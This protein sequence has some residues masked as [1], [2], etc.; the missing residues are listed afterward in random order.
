MS[1]P[2]MD[3]RSHP[4]KTTR[5]SGHAPSS[6]HNGQGQTHVVSHDGQGRRSLATL[7]ERTGKAGVTALAATALLLASGT[8]A[9]AA[10]DSATSTNT[11][12]NSSVHTA[13]ANSS[14]GS[15]SDTTKTT[16]AKN[17]A[18][19]EKDQNIYGILKAN[20]STKNVYVVNQFNVTKAGTLSDYGK[21][22]SVTNLSNTKAIA[23]DADRHSIDVSKGTFYYQG[24]P[25]TDSTELP[26]NIDISYSLN[27]KGVKAAD[28]VGKSGTVRVEI[29]TTK[30][31]DAAEAMYYKKYMLQISFT[32]P[33]ASTTNISA[34]DSGV[35]AD[36]GGNKQI[37]FMVMPGSDGK[38]VFTANSS[39]F[40]MSAIS[41]AAA[42]FSM[43]LGNA[44]D[45]SSLTN[46]MQKLANGMDQ[47]ADGSTT[48]TSGSTTFAN[49]VST[50]NSGVAKAAN[51]ASQLVDG[52]SSLSAGISQYT[53]AISKLAQGSSSLNSGIQKLSQGVQKSSEGTSKLVSGLK[54]QANSLSKDANDTTIAAARE[55]YE[56]A[57]TDYSSAVSTYVMNHV[58]DKIGELLTADDA[59]K[60][61]I[62]SELSAEADKDSKVAALK[63]N[64]ATTMTKLMK[65]VGEKGSVETLNSV[66]TQTEEL[67]SGMQQLA[68]GASQTAD[69]SKSFDSGL[70]KAAQG[71]TSLTSGAQQ[72]NSG[73]STFTSG[74]GSLSSGTSQV[75]GGASSLADGITQLNSGIGRMAESTDA[76]PSTMKKEI[77]KAMEN[78]TGTV[79]PIDFISTKNTDIQHV[80]F[81]LTTRALTKAT[82]T[83]KAVDA[84]TP[85]FLQRVKNL[86]TGS[87]SGE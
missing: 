47:L 43:D 15:S 3:S 26:W 86:F 65:L 34:G 38:L 71:G 48:L 36:A 9:Y 19:Y 13:S 66:A 46:G 21:Y 24:T 11:N 6:S 16:T 75:S 55:A 82:T 56:K 37:T 7:L 35:I 60:A 59:K 44:F 53:S 29:D 77:K 57:M 85:S 2:H 87:K 79:T 39:N 28:L 68:E 1:N 51:G 31:P 64:I 49:G 33:T 72:L 45:T 12:T 14:D 20:G 63:A 17:T 76:I 8:V 80:Q 84:P 25:N 4:T 22:D 18:T 78:F 81:M 67:D 73:I 70:Q 23:S 54:S 41:I 62:M 32:V 61:S 50:L 83:K 58:S 69:G 27:G 40:T 42:P 52:S 74:L 10:T 5:N 30:N